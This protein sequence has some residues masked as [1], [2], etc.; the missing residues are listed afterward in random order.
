VKGLVAFRPFFTDNVIID[1]DNDTIITLN[2]NC[3]YDSNLDQNDSDDDKWGDVCD[4]CPTNFDAFNLDFENDTIGD[5]CDIDDDNDGINDFVDNCHFDKNNNQSN[6]DSDAFGDVCDN[7]VND[8]NNDQ[9]D[10][11]KDGLGNACDTDDDDDSI[12]DNNDNCAL[13]S[14]IDQSDTD[15]DGVG[16]VCDVCPLIVNPDQ[17]DIDNDGVGDICDI[18]LEV[19]LIETDVR[20]NGSYSALARIFYSD[21]IDNL[22]ILEKIVVF[23]ENGNIVSETNVSNETKAFMLMIDDYP[24]YGSILA[25]VKEVERVWVKNHSTIGVAFNVLLN[26][27]GL[28][29]ELGVEQL[30][31]ISEW[32][33]GNFTTVPLENNFSINFTDHLNIQANNHVIFEI[34]VC[35]VFDINCSLNNI[36]SF[37]GNLSNINV[38]LFYTYNNTPF[39]TSK[40]FTISISPEREG[41]PK[42]PGWLRGDMHFHTALSSNA[43]YDRV[44]DLSDPNAPNPVALNDIDDCPQEGD[45]RVEFDSSDLLASGIT[46][47]GTGLGAQFGVPAGPLGILFGG[48]IGNELG[49][50]IADAVQGNVQNVVIHDIIANPGI[51]VHPPFQEK[52]KL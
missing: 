43:G 15:G 33:G 40:D 10:T 25:N 27:M 2:D 20:F 45:P 50:L 5:V 49:Q 38:V 4:F 51:L 23:N 32:L 52:L 39:N 14:N 21:K 9:A 47:L 48:A 24:L 11:D 8:F 12:L 26:Y 44:L 36:S 16:D 35:K 37:V 28:F 29:E 22:T 1:V 31:A 3:P 46:G 30:T 42:S 6:S 41:V 17:A 7:C 34:D 19:P 13:N 18:Q